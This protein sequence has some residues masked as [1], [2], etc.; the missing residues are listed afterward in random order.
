MDRESWNEAYAAR[1][2]EVTGIDANFAME[3]AK[4]ADDAFADGDEP[5]FAA[6]EE[7][8]YWDADE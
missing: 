3:C 7:L 8:T 2:Q 6:D 4:V 1:I 5:A